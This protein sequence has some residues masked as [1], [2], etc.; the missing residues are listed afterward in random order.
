MALLLT[1]LVESPNYA[2][3]TN[4]NVSYGMPPQVGMAVHAAAAPAS[5][6]KQRNSVLCRKEAPRELLPK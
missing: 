4:S 3:F 2:R 1:K 5:C 6:L